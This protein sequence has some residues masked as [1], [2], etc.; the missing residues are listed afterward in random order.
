MKPWGH[1]IIKEIWLWIL[2]V[3]NT[4]GEGEESHEEKEREITNP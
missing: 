4:D 3:V 1:V 2:Y